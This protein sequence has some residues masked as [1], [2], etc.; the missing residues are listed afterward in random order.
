ME[1]EDGNCKNG[2]DALNKL[3]FTSDAVWRVA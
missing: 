1:R 2:E 3:R